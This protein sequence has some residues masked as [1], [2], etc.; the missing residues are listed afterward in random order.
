MKFGVDK[1]AAFVYF[2]FSDDKKVSPFVF[3]RQSVVAGVL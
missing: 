2:R 1:I 3:D